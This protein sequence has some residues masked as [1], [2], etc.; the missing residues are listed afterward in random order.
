MEKIDITPNTIETRGLSILSLPIGI[1]QSFTAIGHYSDGS[2]NNITDIVD[3]HSSDED[4]GL[5]QH[6][7]ILTG[8][9]TGETSVKATVS[10]ISSNDI[11]VKVTDA[12][13]TSIQVSPSP[14][15]IAHGQSAV[16]TAIG[17]FSDLSST[18]VTMSVDWHSDNSVVALVDTAGVLRGELEGN[19]IINATKD[20]I[21]SNNVS[22]EVTSAILTSIQVSPSNISVAVGQTVPLVAIGSYSDLSSRDI[23][24]SVTWTSEDTDIVIVDTDGVLKGTAQGNTRLVATKLDVESNHVAIEVSSA[25]L[26]SI[27]VN[28]STVNIAHG[29]TIPLK[30]I[31]LYSDLSSSDIT[32]DVTWV[33]DNTNIAT[34]D[35]EGLLKAT[36]KGNTNATALKDGI[37]SNSVPV[38]ITDAVLTSIQVTPSPVSVGNG[39]TTP[40]TAIG[41]YSDLSSTDIT[42][43][44][45]W[46]SDNTDV[47]T[48]DM[49]GLLS[50]VSE[51]NTTL[52]AAKDSILS[53]QVIVEVIGSL[54]VCGNLPGYPIDTSPQ[55]GINNDSQTNA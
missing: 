43:S 7:G 44:V 30:A 10:G 50:G 31:G 49:N 36:A 14:V 28:P 39:Q 15:S 42:T 11:L 13:L 17:F 40:L 26:T 16:M 4:I 24:T 32:S 19:A 2:S 22:V 52:H 6:K 53:S 5:F 33:S 18:D 55:G 27:Q 8:L 21:L 37:S 45:T 34:I 48:I 3:W 51:G 46:I 23:T 1:K 20:G 47:A 38:D 25:V 9:S 41:F 54:M 29:Q 12:V 35:T